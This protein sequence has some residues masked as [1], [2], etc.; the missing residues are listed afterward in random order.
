MTE[1]RFS[2]QE[3]LVPGQTYAEKFDFLAKIG[4]AGVEI[5]S[6]HLLG[7]IKELAALSASTGVVVSS[8]C[9]GFEG[10][11]IDSN[12]EARRSAI[13]ATKESLDALAA[14]GGAG[15]VVPAGFA[16]G[17]KALPPFKP[18]RTA[19]E[20]SEALRDAL[21][22]LLLHAA[23]VGVSLF[24][25]PINRYESHFLNTLA[26]AETIVSAI[27]SPWLSITADLFHMNI[28]EADPPGELRR[29]GAKLGHVHLAD[30][31]RKLPGQGHLD[32]AA[33][34]S[35]LQRVGYKGWLAI[36]CGRLTDPAREL[37]VAL[38]HLRRS[39]H[40]AERL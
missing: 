10:G 37:P 27:S 34:F 7:T 2:C 14:V 16:L 32:F 11:L 20:D 6:H 35:A 5:W 38:D 26:E 4:F 8:G 29:V 18:P 9:L 40:I 17:S 30:S 1:P 19:E 22:Q 31:N 33:H 15:F 3:Q 23:G 25:E 24:L 12:E 21:A 13:A 36:E 39:W 28:E